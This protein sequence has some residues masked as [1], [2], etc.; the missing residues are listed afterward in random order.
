[1]SEIDFHRAVVEANKM[2]VKAGVK[3]YP[4]NPFDV[5]K[6]I[7][8]CVCRKFATA[9]NW[10]VDIESFGSESAIIVEME[11]RVVIFYDETKPQSHINFSIL[12]ELGHLLLGHPLHD[13]S[14]S[15]E[16][17]HRY[18]V[19]A[20]YFAAQTLMPSSIIAALQYRQSFITREFLV[21]YFGVSH[22]A[23]SK[24][25]TTMRNTR[26]ITLSPSEREYDDIIVSMASNFLETIRPSYSFFDYLREEELQRTRESWY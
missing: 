9:R 8:D 14:M 2:L 4:F 19:E 21:K 18:E 7:P 6:H 26:S 11:G 25:L 10:G 23:A 16:A 22:D 12:H 24:R 5:V 20:N 17:Y 15:P 13:K 3:Y 1:M